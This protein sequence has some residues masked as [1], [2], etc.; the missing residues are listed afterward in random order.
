MRR[1]QFLSLVIGSTAAKWPP[2]AIAQPSRMR[3]LGVLFVYGEDHPEVPSLVGALKEGLQSHGWIEGQTI[4][5]HVRFCRSNAELVKRYAG[6]LINL[7]PNII[8][9]QGVVGA[10]AMKQATQSIPVVFVQVQ[11]PVG[12]GF[13]TNLARPEGNLTGWTNFE[14]SIVGKWLQLLKDVGPGVTRVMG[15]I[16]PDNRPRWNGYTAAFE[17][18]GPPLGIA[19][20]MA[21]IHDAKDVERA[22]AAWANESNGGLVVLPD[23]TTGVHA[24]LII[25]LAQRHRQPAVYSYGFYARAGGLIAYSDSSSGQFKSAGSYIDRL[26]RGAKVSDLPIQATDRFE[27]VINLKTAA[28]IGV[29]VPPSLL[30]VADEL[31]E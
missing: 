22:I 26:L 15:M 14:Y 5:M 19:S 28:A 16:N 21:G 30:A 11:D 13:V 12:G 27:T 24:K 31:I 17:K 7:K 1:R 4:E 10:A 9:A 3:R 20:Q 18:Y 2:A 6:E 8:F 25:E 29:T 23:A